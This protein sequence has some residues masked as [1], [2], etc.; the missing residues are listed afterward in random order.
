MR[1]RIFVLRVIAVFFLLI[2]MGGIGNA[3]VAGAKPPED[4]PTEIGIEAL[5]LIAFWG[6]SISQLPGEAKVAVDGYTSAKASVDYIAVRVVLQR[7]NGSA[8]ADVVS[9]A[10]E[11][12]NTSYVDG[13]Y[14][15]AT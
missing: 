3:A 7:W 11:K 14:Y 2:F 8:W 15:S 6:C 13:L 1:T 4:D 12:Y 9:H 5:Q 10:F